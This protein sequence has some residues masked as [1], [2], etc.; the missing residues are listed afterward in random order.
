MA[1]VT[2]VF[3]RYLHAELLGGAND[4]L[5]RSIAFS[6]THAIYLIEAG[7]GVSDMACIY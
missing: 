1:Q 3:L 5:P 2:P 6:V 4:A 7:Y